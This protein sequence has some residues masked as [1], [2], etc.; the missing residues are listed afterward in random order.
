M[1]SE[2]ILK[3]INNR[4]YEW[5]LWKYFRNGLAHGF[6][7]CHGGFEHQATYFSVRTIGGKQ[8]LVIDPQSFLRDFLDGIKNYLADLQSASSLDSLAQDFERVFK[9]VFIDGN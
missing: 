6:A 9:E 4:S 7:V 5:I 1:L 2:F 3:T 8:T